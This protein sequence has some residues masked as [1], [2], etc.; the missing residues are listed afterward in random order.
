MSAHPAV[1]AALR[2]FPPSDEQQ[3]AIDHPP[4]PLAIVAGAG[5]GK[6]AVMAA[7]IAQ[8]VV[9][10][11][12]RPSQILGLAFT[13]KAARELADR[14]D[15]ALSHV[16]LPTGEEVSVFTYH[17]FADRILRDYGPKV[18]V[19]PDTALLT[20]AQAYML[21]GRLLEGITFDHLRPTWIPGLIG[22]VRSLADNC[23]NHL[24]T[25]EEVV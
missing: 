11:A 3:R 16:D 19:E 21:V 1:I 6:T 2:G 17:G 5:S 25:P 4:T 18:G 23:A 13:N 15:L 8:L 10:G 14:I 22:K 20:E 12:A 9:S 24:R 7:R